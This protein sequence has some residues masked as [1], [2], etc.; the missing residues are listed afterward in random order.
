[1]IRVFLDPVSTVKLDLVFRGNDKLNFTSRLADQDLI[2]LCGCVNDIKGCRDYVRNID[3]SYN[4][5]TDISIG[6]LSGLIDK[7]KSIESLNL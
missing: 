5:L 6:E 7:C 4:L 3:F 2:I 1:M